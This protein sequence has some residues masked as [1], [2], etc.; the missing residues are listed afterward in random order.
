MVSQIRREQGWL[1]HTR[2]AHGRTSGD[3][4]QYGL[5]HRR[6][7]NFERCAM[8]ATNC[9]SLQEELDLFMKKIDRGFFENELD[10]KIDYQVNE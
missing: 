5:L 6:Q 8:S 9:C 7:R 4:R 3:G 2:G 10:C 1:Y